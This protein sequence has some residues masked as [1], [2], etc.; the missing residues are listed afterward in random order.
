MRLR[1]PRFVAA[2]KRKLP[3]SRQARLAAAI[4]PASMRFRF[5]IAASRWQGRLTRVMGGNGALTE[6]LMRDHWLRELT[7]R[8]PFP[9]PWRLRG[10]EVLDRYATKGAVL[11][12]STHLP[13]GEIPLR[14]VIELGYPTPLPVADPGRIIGDE[15]YVVTGMTQRIHAIPA[16]P[17]VLARVRRFLTE[18]TSVVFLA[19][20]EFAGPLSA[21]P[22]RLARRLNVPV[23]FSWAELAHDGVVDVTIC[24][25]PH[26]YCKTEQEIANN[27]RLLGEIN[28]R[29]LRSLGVTSAARAGESAQ[30]AG[31]VARQRRESVRRLR[32]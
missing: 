25:A 30:P 14:A 31:V 7:L 18:G 26:P 27:L 32:P 8:G 28:D 29:I 20:S 12:Y 16:S 23:V 10:R 15:E 6:A 17:Y 22:L 1:R 13:L 3:L 19:D 2:L 4:L 11:Y 21:N 24:A 9:V 5:A